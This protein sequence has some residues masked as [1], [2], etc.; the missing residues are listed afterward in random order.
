MIW[1]REEYIAHMTFEYTDKEMFTELFGLLVGLD[2][3]WKS[4]GAAA[5]ELDLSA[6]C[7]DSVLYTWAGGYT[8]AVTGIS[9]RIIEDTGEHTI[10]SDHMGRKQKLI[11][12]SI[13]I[14]SAKAGL[15]LSS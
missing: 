8:G 3:E 7:W 6:F 13:G 5:D 4:Q 14:H 1:N 2:G 10:S 11:K 9:P 12:S 15:I